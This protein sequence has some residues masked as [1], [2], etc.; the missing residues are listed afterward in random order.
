MKIRKVSQ[1]EVTVYLSEQELGGYDI[2]PGEKIPESAALHRFLFELM[3]TV[4]IETGFNPYGGQVV[5][6][7]TPLQNGM[8]L[9]ISKIGMKKPLSRE[10]FKKAKSV[11]VKSKKSEE[12]SDISHEEMLK[13]VENIARKRTDK[14]RKQKGVFV[15]ENFS[16]MESAFCMIDHDALDGCSLYRN[17][18]K[19]AIVSNHITGSKYY[20]ILSE[21]A[22]K[23]I[24][25][26]IAAADICEGWI[27]LADGAELKNM[28]EAIQKI[29]SD[30]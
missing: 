28:A 15:F 29:I 16:D 13:L 24:T 10:E 20:N 11:R 5:V 23:I 22:E 14:H 8:S 27:K 2:K 1:N 9:T 21:F 6:E 12:L 3:D 4:Y 17:K 18:G 19:Y 30:N 26:D 7:A 25:A